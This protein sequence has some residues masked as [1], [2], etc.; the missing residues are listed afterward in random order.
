M[1][2]GSGRAHELSDQQVAILSNYLLEMYGNP[3]AEVT[4]DQVQ[5]LRE[6][7]AL[8]EG[9]PDLLLLSR[10]AMLAAA[11]IVLLLVIWLIQRRRRR[12]NPL[13]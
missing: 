11:V 1:A 10:I 13:E 2:G 8:A 9:Q 12:R 4:V 5:A 3:D 7:S 6:G